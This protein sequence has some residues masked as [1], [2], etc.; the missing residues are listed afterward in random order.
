MLAV[1]LH[2]PTQ[3]LREKIIPNAKLTHIDKLMS[4]LKRY[5]KA[6]GNRLFYEYIMIA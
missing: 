2:A 5:E 4:T 1:S 3:E 6:T